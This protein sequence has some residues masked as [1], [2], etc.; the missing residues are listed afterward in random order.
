M[1]YWLWTVNGENWPNII[2]AKVWGVKNQ[3]KTVDAIVGDYI[4]FYVK[5]SGCF[6]GIFKIISEWKYRD[7]DL[8]DVEHIKMFLDYPY[9]CQLEEICLGKARFKDLIDSLDCKQNVPSMPQFILQNSSWGA[10]NVGKPLSLHD[11]DL[12][13]NDILLHPFSKSD[14]SSLESSNNN[15]SPLILTNKSEIDD[16]EITPLHYD[17]TVVPADYTLEVLHM[18]FKSGEIIIPSFQR[19]YVWSKIQSSRL[20]ESFFMGLPIPPIYFYIDKNENLLVIDG[21]QRLRTIFHYFEGDFR[22]S[23]DDKPVKEFRLIGINSSQRFF[24]KTFDELDNTDQKFLKNQVLRCVLIKQLHPN[25]DNSSIYHIFERLNTG[26]TILRDQ[27]VRNCVYAGSFNVL[28]LS[29][30]EYFNWRLF[31]GKAEIDNRQ[32]DVELILHY[33]AL[34]H[35]LKNYKRPMKDFL[36]NFMLQNQNAPK[37]FLKKQEEI[38]KKICD[39]LIKYCGGRPL[40][41]KGGLNKSVFDAIFVAFAKHIDEIPSDIKKRLESLRKDSIFQKYTT[42][43]TTNADAINTRFE[44]AEKILFLNR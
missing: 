31:L 12:I 19:K 39:S 5:R 21:S 3:R 43:G 6:Q 27:E 24:R 25:A 38:F 13:K 2:S 14:D 33:L 37:E 16:S 32:K 40:N 23:N 11:F 26:G 29:L 1:N 10:A 22:N 15:S 44:I 8:S 20:I 42:E 9:R 4:V 18:K 28:L 34:F 7:D 35:N 30:N 41:P 36:N 17:I